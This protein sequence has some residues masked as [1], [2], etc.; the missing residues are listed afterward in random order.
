VGWLIDLLPLSYQDSV[1]TVGA[2]VLGLTAGV[3]GSLA[4]LRERSLVG[5]ALAHAAL[6]GVCVAFL[7]TGVKDASGLLAGAAVA[8][9]VGAVAMVAIERTSRIRADAAIGIVLSCFFSLGIVLLTFIQKTNDADQAGLDKYLFGQAAGLLERDVTV[10][11]GLAAVSLALVALLYR[12]FK[13]TLFDPAFAGSTGLP[14][15]ALELAMTA[16]LVVAIVAGI[17]IVGAILMVALLVVPAVTARQLTSR[18]WVMLVL[19]GAIGALIGVTGSLVSSRAEVPTGPVIVVVGFLVV[20][21]AVLLAPGR[22]VV[23]RAGKLARD[24]RSALLEGVL[25]DLETMLHSGPPPTVA[26]IVAATGRSSRSVRRAL[27]DLDRAGLVARDGDRVLL[28]A[29]GAAAAHELLARR[30]LWS[31][32]LE[33]GW[34]LELPDAREPDPRDLRRSLGDDAVDRLEALAAG[35]EA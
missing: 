23:W 27:A 29:Q 28:S 25:V 31:A 19:A 5:D 9:L 2:A 21:G 8:G 35:A 32:W 7:L 24:R 30:D 11:A 33:H 6:P 1:V 14:L 18:L 34:K 17:R 22:G 10:M 15:R 16:L 20:L 13:V 4:V 12:P 3:L 26:Q